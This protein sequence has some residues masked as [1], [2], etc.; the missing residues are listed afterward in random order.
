MLYKSNHVGAATS[1]LPA[2]SSLALSDPP[3][4]RPGIN[5]FPWHKTQIRHGPVFLLLSIVTPLRIC[6]IVRVSLLHLTAARVA[7]RGTCL[8]RACSIP[9]WWH[10]LVSMITTRVSFLQPAGTSTSTPRAFVVCPDCNVR[11]TI[12]TGSVQVGVS[13]GGPTARHEIIPEP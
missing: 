13:L 2:I 8:F 4:S 9:S 7:I 10:D 1:P 5:K 3:R 12:L 6:K 11:G